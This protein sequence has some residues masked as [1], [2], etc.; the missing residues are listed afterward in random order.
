MN[1]DKQGE[2]GVFEEGVFLPDP[3]EELDKVIET[4]RKNEG[5]IA[6]GLVRQFQ[7]AGIETVETHD[8]KDGVVIRALGLS[9]KNKA[10]LEQTEGVEVKQFEGS[11]GDF[12]TIAQPP[13]EV[14]AEKVQEGLPQ[15]YKLEDRGVDWRK[16]NPAF[17][18]RF[19]V[20][21]P[22]GFAVKEAATAEKAIERVLQDIGKVQKP[23]TPKQM[24]PEERLDKDIREIGGEDVRVSDII[25]VADIELRKTFPPPSFSKKSE[26]RY[27]DNGE[28]RIRVASHPVVHGE[29]DSDIFIGIGKNTPDADIIIPENST[30]QD[31]IDAVNKVLAQPPKGEVKKG[32]TDVKEEFKVGDVIST[33]GKSNMADPVTIREIKGNTLKFTDAKGV[34]YAGMARAT[35]RNLIKGGSWERVATTLKKPSK[36]KGGGA[37]SSTAAASAQ[38]GKGFGTIEPSEKVKALPEKTRPNKVAEAMPSKTQINALDE[39]LKIASPATRGEAREGARVLRKSLGK[40]SQ[41]TVVAHEALKKA[42]HAFTFMNREDIYDFIDRM[43]NGQK[44]KTQRLGLIAEKF[45]GMLDSRKKAVQDLGKGHLEKFYENYF[46]HIW[47]DPKQAEKAIMQIFGKRTL[48][49]SKAFLKKR[50]LMT[51]KEGRDAG[52]ELV[53]E[54]P[55]DLVLLKTFEMDRYLMAHNIIQDLKARSLIKFVYSRS[56]P[57]EGYKKIDDRS[58]T[59][60]MPPEITKKEAYDS[61]LVEQLMGLARSIGID[62]QRFVA[63]GGRRWGYAKWPKDLPQEA[64]TV[65]TKYAGPVSVLAHE[66]GHILGARYSLYETLR[67]AR[68]GSQKEITRGKKKG[69]A[70]F[71]PS[72]EAV[73]HRKVIDKEWRAL[74]DAR[75]KNTETTPGFKKYL[76]RSVEKEAVMLEALIH[77]PNEFKRVAPKLFKLFKNFINEHS[78]LRPLLDMKPSL[79]LGESEAKI[80]VPGFTVL[81]HYYAPDPVAKILNNYLSPGL[82]N[83][84]NFLIS[85]TYNMLR[86]TGNILNQAQLAL[87]GFH[88][89]NVTTDMIASTLGQGLRQLAIKGQRIEGVGHIVTAP[90]APLFRIWEGVRLRKAYKQQIDT[91]EDD[92][93]R[94]TIKAVVLAD[95]RDRM[96][97]FYYNQQIKALKKT[98]SDILKGA[99][100]EKIKGAFKL[101]FNTFGATLEALAKPLME[102]YVPTGKLGLFSMMAQSEMQRAEAGQID[103]E[104][105]HERLI[106]SWDSV[107]NRMGQLVYDNLFWNKTLKDVAMLAIRSVGWN[108]GSWR[109]YGGA[110]FDILGTKGRLERGDVLLSQKMAYTIGAVILYGTLGATIMY[111]LTG[112]GPEELKDYFFPKT[113]NKNPDGSDERLSLPTYAKDWFAYATQPIKTITHKIHPLWGLLADL[114]KNKDYFNTEI[115]HPGDPLSQQLFSVAKHIGKEFL[116][117]SVRNYKKMQKAQPSGQNVWVSITGITSAPSYIVR[118]P[119][120]KLMYRY[121]IENV[122]DITKTRE[123]QELREYRRNIKNQLRKGSPVNR[124]VV[125]AR[126][127]NASF[128]RLRKDVRKEPF[129]EAFNRLSLYQALNVYA[130][131]DTEERTQTKRLLRGK[132]GSARKRTPEMKQLYKELTK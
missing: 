53:S 20:V 74:A 111:L 8:T 71:V 22:Q 79:V 65:R 128:N 27:Y 18:N 118:S 100:K 61:L 125:I 28:I 62:A 101:P 29:S 3:K 124:K 114:A 25:D 86:A 33:K 36:P 46:P 96:D 105:L 82:R 93:L 21:N 113:G 5:D 109:E 32:V 129:A 43:E 48:A 42:H 88:G 99:P 132:Y 51:V 70:R 112:E 38:A 34:E 44:Q 107:D 126:I 12:I 40:L 14:T 95:G 115:R 19:V 92:K 47:K 52:L 16:I 89:L 24:F 59:V 66:I 83:N 39:L 120:Q 106:S 116:P 56:Q 130:I 108:L 68:E 9:D 55:V 63:I 26:A 122:P 121:I 4:V 49:G 84:E 2:I 103:P 119:A 104:Q 80:K 78:E 60:Y 15:G 31:V 67:R 69:Q 110:V 30:S 97:P 7:D 10:I 117:L 23:K 35:V 75:A 91:I 45:R 57:P 54:N 77:A 17:K 98:I 1:L 127:G 37:V 50:T 87:S 41:E 64:K 76:R 6:A 81:G 131:A 13:T 72:P 102:W 58:F 90:V 123:K 11:K 85:G 94:N 73:A